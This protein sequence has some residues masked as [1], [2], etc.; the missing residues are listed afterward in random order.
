VQYW[1]GGHYTCHMYSYV[2]VVLRI[3]T[4]A[5]GCCKPIW[6]Y[7][8]IPVC[9]SKRAILLRLTQYC[10]LKRKQM[11]LTREVLSREVEL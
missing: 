5:D 8:F 1:P 2:P 10:R 3:P 6:C 7:D 9:R 4:A 11:I